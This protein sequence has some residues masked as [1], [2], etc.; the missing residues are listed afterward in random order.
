MEFLLQQKL[1]EDKKMA[2]FLKLNSYWYKD[3]NRN[4]DSYKNFVTA[5]KDKYHLKVTDKLSDAIDNIDIISGIL[6]TLK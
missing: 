4:S 5:M 2:T 3:L 6:D 1:E